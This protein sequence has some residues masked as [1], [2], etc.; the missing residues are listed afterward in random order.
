MKAENKLVYGAFFSSSDMEIHL[1]C[2]EN[3]AEFAFAIS[4]IRRAL[5]RSGQNFTA[6]GQMGQGYQIAAPGTN[7]A[8]VSRLQHVALNAMREGVI[9]GTETP[10]ELLSAE[11]RRKHEAVTEKLA[12]RLALV[13]RRALP[14]KL[15]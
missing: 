5:R 6:R 2:K 15:K 3:T 8:E 14:A 13:N 9:L 4:H 1:S 7:H 12:T 10:L 11:E